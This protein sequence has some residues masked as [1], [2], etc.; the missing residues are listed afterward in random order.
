M[1]KKLRDLEAEE[2][3]LDAE[4]ASH[5]DRNLKLDKEFMKLSLFKG[6][7]ADKEKEI[8]QNVNDYERK[9]TIKLE[10]QWQVQNKI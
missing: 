7:V 6:V 4:I 1:N 10:S 3:K 2:A 9:L 5:E 8:W